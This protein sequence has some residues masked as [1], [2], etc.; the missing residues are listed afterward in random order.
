MSEVDPSIVLAGKPVQIDNPLDVQA[1][2]YSLKQLGLQTQQAQQDYQDSQTLRSLY[3][4]NLDPTT[5]QLN[6]QGLLKDA[7][8]AGLGQKAT[9]I[10]QMY[11]AN[12]KTGSEITQN[13]ASAAKSTA[14]A[15]QANQATAT[16]QYNL[17][18]TKLTDIN[19]RVASLISKPDLSRQDVID[20]VNQLTDQHA[21]APAARDQMISQIPQNPADL[22]DFLVRIG[23]QN[24]TVQQQTAAR[25]ALAP[26]VEYKDTGP[27]LQPVDTNALT[28]PN[29]Q[30][31][32]KGQ[33]PDEAAKL[34]FQRSG[35]LNDDAKQLAVDRLLQGEPAT[36]VLGNLGRGAQ[37]AADL[38]DIQNLLA[39][40]A[41]TRGIDASGILSAT[42]GVIADNREATVLGNR[43]GSIAPRVQEAVNFGQIAKDASAQVPRSGFLPWNKLSQMA[44][45]Q[46]SDP[47]LA[48]LKASTVSLIN[49]Y[50]GAVGGGAVHVHDQETAERLLSAAQ[51]P[52]AYN[53]VVDQLITEAKGALAAPGQ[54]RGQMGIGSKGNPTGAPAAAGAPAPT[55][56]VVPIK[57]DADY[58][59]LPSGTPFIAPDGSHRVKP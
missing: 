42:Q 33:T 59:A 51:S 23:T 8:G 29:P 58:A 13:Y 46:I 1:K 52:E 37:G 6:Q 38:R 53:A 36:K 48:K 16:S 12:Q 41:K 21:L 15:G 32:V 57:S 11:L 4:Q 35:A 31:I 18:Q 54:V 50:A 44:D 5:G 7:Y 56:A 3:A 17:D 20:Q 49:A 45:T 22:K 19:N 39:T 30:P 26:K 9:A 24:Q 14:D 40:T 10:N 47:A 28:N 55:G 27:T 34:Q 43:E 2:A 25:Q